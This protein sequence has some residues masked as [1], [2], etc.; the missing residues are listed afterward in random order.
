[1]NQLINACSDVKTLV[2]D[3]KRDL[4]FEIIIRMRRAL[5]SVEEGRNISTGFLDLLP[6][7]NCDELFIKLHQLADRY[8]EVRSVFV[9]H[10]GQYYEEKRQRKLFAM[11]ECLTSGNVDCALRAAKGT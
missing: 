5:L 2:S 10:A 8:T 6:V 11:R 7:E 4:L 3:I 1:M 9:K